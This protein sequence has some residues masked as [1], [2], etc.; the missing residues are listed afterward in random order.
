V[1]NRFFKSIAHTHIHAASLAPGAFQRVCVAATLM[2]FA[3]AVAIVR[4]SW[5]FSKAAQ[6]E[7]L[8]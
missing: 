8:T 6:I 3:S 7:L 5:D 4:F 2:L 1:G